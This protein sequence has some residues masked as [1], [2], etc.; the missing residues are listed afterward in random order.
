MCNVAQHIKR[1]KQQIKFTIISNRK[2]LYFVP[3]P[4]KGYYYFFARVS[5]YSYKLLVAGC[6]FVKII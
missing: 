5:F 4:L 2:F 1:C 3:H 6:R